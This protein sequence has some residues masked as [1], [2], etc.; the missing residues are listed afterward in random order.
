MA[1][2]GNS[3]IA[4]EYSSA[5]CTYG[6]QSAIVRQDCGRPLLAAYDK[7]SKACAASTKV[8]G[9]HL[10]R[11]VKGARTTRSKML[12]AT[13]VDTPYIVAIALLLS[14]FSAGW[15]SRRRYP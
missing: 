15:A 1:G 5:T 13:G 9:V 6:R 12:A 10:S 4:S 3:E 14:A 8:K 7:G 2:E 11:T